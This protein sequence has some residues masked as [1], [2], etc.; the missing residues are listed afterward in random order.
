MAIEV[1]AS[2]QHKGGATAAILLDEIRFKKDALNS[3]RTERRK[4][5]RELVG[6]TFKQLVKNYGNSVTEPKWIEVGPV[7]PY[8]RASKK[9]D[10]Q[11]PI[12]DLTQISTEA[13]RVYHNN[14]IIYTDRHT[15]YS[16]VKCVVDNLRQL[17]INSMILAY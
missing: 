6:N 13:F 7:D 5:K 2:Q 1:K 17:D 9:T 3:D 14:I 15:P 11:R 8:I 16:A 10:F 4:V 12:Y